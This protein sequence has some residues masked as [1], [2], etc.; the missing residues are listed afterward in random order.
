[1]FTKYAK[2][3]RTFLIL[4]EQHFSE[5][6]KD[7]IEV[8]NLT[9]RYDD[10][11]AVDNL[12]F[13]VD[14]GQILGFL[15]PN[16][17]G[18]S[19]T[20]NILTGY[21]SPTEGTILI[22]GYDMVRKP[23]KAKKCIGYLPEQPPVYP[24]MKV[25][26]Y[27]DFV[28]ELKGMTS[29]TERAEAVKEAMEKT[30]LT[31]VSERLIKHLSKGY[32]QRVGIAQAIVTKPEIV[33]LD[34]PTVGLDPVQ[35]IEIRDLIRSFAKD[36]TVIL[37]SHILSEISAV[38]DTVMIINNGRLIVSDT[39]EGLSKHLNVRKGLKLTV[40]GDAQKAIEIISG[41]EGVGEVTVEKADEEKA[42][43]N[44]YTD[45]DEDIREKVYFELAG[46]KIAV[47]EQASLSLDLEEMFL[48]FIKKSE[49]PV[50]DKNT[51]E[52][53]TE[54]VNTEEASAEEVNTEEEQKGDAE[55]ESNI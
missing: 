28:A 13:T 20:M 6:E 27:L 21:L 5:E 50:E 55:N 4:S 8:R 32:K 42:V 46:A 11:I 35:I 25:R 49:N 17:A 12:S 15:G 24:E 53:N 16:G 48:E 43:L 45:N 31:S 40:K 18:K 1:M 26:E 44:V 47:L 2:R 34:E 51:E 37:S 52:A 7:L 3:F 10:H 41:M 39:T 29:K 22:N 23:G 54:E 19:T 36:H 33:I 14:K 9:K 30:D 38:C